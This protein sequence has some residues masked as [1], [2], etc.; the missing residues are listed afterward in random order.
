MDL[1][2]LDRKKF[3]EYQDWLDSYERDD[4]LIKSL[5]TKLV[6]SEIGPHISPERLVGFFKWLRVYNYNEY[7]KI[8]KNFHLIS[9]SLMNDRFNLLPNEIV[10]GILENLPLD[11]IVEYCFYKPS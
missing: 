5:A 9:Q 10:Y 8:S 7:L 6:G 2:E 4:E 11:Q 1:N 3:N